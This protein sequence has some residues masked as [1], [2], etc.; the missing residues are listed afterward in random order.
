[1]VLLL[2]TFAFC[3]LVGSFV[4][5]NMEHFIDKFSLF[6]SVMGV[7]CKVANLLIRRDKIIAVASMLSSKNC[8]PRDREE[9]KIQRKFDRHAR[10]L[11]IYCEVLNESTVFF[12]TVAQ[13]KHSLDTK[14][15]PLNDWMPYDMS[16]DTIFLFS[17]LHQTFGLMVCANASVAHETLIAGMMIQFVISSTVLCLS[18][19]KM[20]TKDLLS[21]DFVW[22]SSYV[23]CMLMQ[24]YLYCWYGN[25]VTLKVRIAI[26]EDKL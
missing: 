15:L 12:G 20:S 7:C 8:T 23:G 10:M 14:T 18:V 1:M 25:E 24:V 19:Y 4:S 2:Y 16:S 6:I 26:P 13:F 21:L 22:C 17:L 9:V 3:G 5:D 11:T